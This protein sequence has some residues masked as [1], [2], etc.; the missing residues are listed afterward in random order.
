MEKIMSKEV[1]YWDRVF[2]VTATLCAIAWYVVFKSLSPFVWPVTKSW[3]H[4][5]FWELSGLLI[6]SIVLIV[7]SIGLISVLIKDSKKID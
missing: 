5:N 6:W 7:S 2:L 4:S 1:I 3:L